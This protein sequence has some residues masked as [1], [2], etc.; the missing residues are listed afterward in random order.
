MEKL[1]LKSL[2][3][4]GDVL[5]SEELKQVYSSSG[6]GSGSDN[7]S[8]SLDCEES[9]VINDPFMDYKVSAC[10]NYNAPGHDCHYKIPIYNNTYHTRYGICQYGCYKGK[11]R[12]VCM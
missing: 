1:K 7:G 4:V 11:R 10:A 2:E 6:S 3:N 9:V 8:G 12:L 5:T